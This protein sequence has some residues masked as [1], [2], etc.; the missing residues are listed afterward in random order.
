[1]G[2]LDIYTKCGLINLNKSD[3]MKDR[4]TDERITELILEKYCTN[5]TGFKLLMTG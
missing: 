5:P 3:Y 1:M 4:G 2:K